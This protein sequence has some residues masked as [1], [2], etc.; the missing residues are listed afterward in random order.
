MIVHIMCSEVTEDFTL[1]YKVLINKISWY[2]I[3]LTNMADC[4]RSKTAVTN[5]YVRNTGIPIKYNTNDN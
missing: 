1:F 3:K 4:K 2:L 5:V